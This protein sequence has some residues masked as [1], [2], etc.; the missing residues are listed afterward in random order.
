ML[1]GRRAAGP[2][3]LPQLAQLVGRLAARCDRT[4]AHT[5][6]H[7]HARTHTHTHTHTHTTHT[8]TYIHA[9]T[10]ARTLYLSLTHTHTHTP[11]AAAQPAGRRPT[12]PAFSPENGWTGLRRGCSA[13]IRAI[14][15]SRDR[16]AWIVAVTTAGPGGR[17]AR[18]A[19]EPR[20]GAVARGRGGSGPVPRPAPGRRPTRP[21]V[22]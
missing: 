6:T 15:A 8:F 5:H 3:R 19:L 21:A 13:A 9:R 2:K 14:P 4:H 16:L 17:L 12:R 22:P 11:T 10:H 7:T 20:D 1:V 18:A